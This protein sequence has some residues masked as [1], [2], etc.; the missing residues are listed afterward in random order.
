[1]PYEQELPE[2]ERS[3]MPLLQK[4]NVFFSIRVLDLALPLPSIML[5]DSDRQTRAQKQHNS[6]QNKPQL[7]EKHILLMRE[8]NT[9]ELSSLFEPS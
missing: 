8:E 6:A 3:E 2:C 7:L 4:Q 9:R 5:S 1:M